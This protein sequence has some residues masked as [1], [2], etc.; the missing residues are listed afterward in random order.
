MLEEAESLLDVLLGGFNGVEDA[1]LD[2]LVEDA[3]VLLE[4]V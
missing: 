3:L 2:D 1:G 4:L